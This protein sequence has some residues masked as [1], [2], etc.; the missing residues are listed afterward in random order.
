[1]VQPLW[2]KI[3]RFLRKLNMKLP[4]DPA[5][6]LLGIHLDKLFIKKYTCTPCSLQHYS[7]YQR[8]CPLTGEWIKKMWYIYK[9]E[10]YSAI[11]KIKIMPFA[12]TWMELEILI[13]N[14]V[15]QKEIDKYHMI[16]LT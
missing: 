15:G 16:S 9:M 12:S 8:K 1:M 14:E 13:R 7:Q 6:T 10:Y 5:I 4:Y 3:W 11:K 2:K